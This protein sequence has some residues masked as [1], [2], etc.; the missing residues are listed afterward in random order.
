MKPR[1]TTLAL[2]FGITLL[3]ALCGV[4]FVLSELEEIHDEME[5]HEAACKAP[6][7]RTR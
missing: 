1:E 5:Q 2:A 3:A 7:I 6:A 4:V